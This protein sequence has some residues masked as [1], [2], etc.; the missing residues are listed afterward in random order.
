MNLKETNH[1]ITFLFLN[2]RDTSQSQFSQTL[3]EVFM[4]ELNR[5][6]KIN[7]LKLSEKATQSTFIQLKKE[8]LLNKKVVVNR[9]RH[10]RE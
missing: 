1:K 8:I 3:S 2:E 7:S 10:R 4:Y 9:G 6:Q 5:L